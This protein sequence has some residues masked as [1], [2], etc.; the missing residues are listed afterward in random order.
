MSDFGRL[1]GALQA[2]ARE[3]FPRADFAFPYR[4]RVVEMAVDRV[5][6]QA[7]RKLAGLPDVLPATMFPGTAGTWA[8]LTSG[9]LVLVQFI[10]GDPSQ[11]IVTHYSTKD[12]PGWRPARL[13][14]DAVNA[15]A[16]GEVATYVYVGAVDDDPRPVARAQGV[17]AALDALKVTVN[18]LA[19]AVSALILPAPAIPPVG[20]VD[21]DATTKLRA[22]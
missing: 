2:I 18:A 10:E 7:V 12:D 4:Y 13:V 11:P 21:A 22:L 5:Q 16:I 20:T 3:A 9:S 19:V 17:Q 8:S 15:V 1:L 6:L 14:I